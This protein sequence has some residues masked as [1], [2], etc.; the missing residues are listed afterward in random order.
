MWSDIL[1]PAYQQRR[2]AELIVEG[3]G[4]AEYAEID[5]PH[6]HDAFLIDVDQ[7]G[8]ALA[9]FLAEVET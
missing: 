5:S 7:V 1:F 3:G 4:R 2:L 9:K 6:G 8:D